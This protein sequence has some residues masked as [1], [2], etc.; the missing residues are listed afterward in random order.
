MAQKVTQS[1]TATFTLEK[2]TVTFNRVYEVSSYSCYLFWYKQTPN[3]EMIFLIDQESYNEQ[4]AT[5][6]WYFL[7]CQK[8]TS[9]I[10]LTARG[11]NSV[12]LC[13]DVST[14]GSPR[15]T[16]DHN[17]RH[18]LAMNTWAR[19]SVWTGRGSDVWAEEGG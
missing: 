4:N 7:N 12:F 19:V 10:S 18:P 6:G 2:E 3:G 16:S 13:N 1:Q 5:E 9:S 11:L 17:M 15:K 8:P 14:C